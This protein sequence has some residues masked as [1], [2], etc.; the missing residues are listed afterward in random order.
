MIKNYT[1]K[2][3]IFQKSIDFYFLPLYNNKAL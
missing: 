3:K 2:L 1:K